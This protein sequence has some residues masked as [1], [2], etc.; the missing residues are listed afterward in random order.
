M[1]RERKIIAVLPS[2]VLAVVLAAG[3]SAPRDPGTGD[4]STVYTVQTTGPS[5]G[6][7]TGQ[8]AAPPTGSPPVTS[9]PVET[10]AP[11]PR[12]W[13]QGADLVAPETSAAPPRVPGT[14]A[15]GKAPV[16]PPAPVQSTRTPDPATKPPS[17][18]PAAPAPR[19]STSAPV[20]P[21]M[22]NTVR[23]GSWSH[24]YVTAYGSQSAVDA[25]RLVEWEPRWFAGH[26]WCGYAFWAGLPVGRKIVLTGKNAG[27][28]VVTNRVYLTTQGGKKPALPAYDLA[29]QTCKGSGTQ[30]VL[31][32]KT[33]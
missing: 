21:P 23:I 19:A 18:A 27:T 9:P 22:G 2:A 25:C 29:L 30:L 10:G 32:T 7:T 15:P 20:S 33:A 5:P 8:T 12:A 16:K 11:P 31:A 17:V 26:D 6:Q 14:T 13:V 4:D 1:N 28:Y 3:C 24:G